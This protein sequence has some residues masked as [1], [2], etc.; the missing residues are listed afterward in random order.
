MNKRQE[1]FVKEIVVQSNKVPEEAKHPDKLT[2]EHIQLIYGFLYSISYFRLNKLWK[3]VK[4]LIKLYSNNTLSVSLFFGFMVVV[5][6]TS[7]SMSCFGNKSTNVTLETRSHNVLSFYMVSQGHP[8]L[9]RFSTFSTAPL[10]A[11]VSDIF[12]NLV[13]NVITERSWNSNSQCGQN[14]YI[15]VKSIYFE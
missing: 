10:M 12:V 3:W 14:A 9:Y 15:S 7:K 4:N 2:T 6:V 13:V 5:F 8:V 11:Q 1:I